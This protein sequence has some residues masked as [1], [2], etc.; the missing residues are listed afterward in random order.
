MAALEGWIHRNKS[1]FKANPTE[2][3]LVLHDLTRGS[4]ALSPFG[5]YRVDFAFLGTVS[6]NNCETLKSSIKMLICH[7]AVPRNSS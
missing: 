5:L 7:I 3:Q 2:L 1:Y 4:V 6:A